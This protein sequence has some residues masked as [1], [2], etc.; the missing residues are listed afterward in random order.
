MPY[1]LMAIIFS[2]VFSVKKWGYFS[3]SNVFVFQMV[4]IK[5]AENLAYYYMHRKTISSISY[6]TIRIPCLLYTFDIFNNLIKKCFYFLCKLIIIFYFTL[7]NYLL[8]IECV[9]NY[10]LLCF[11]KKNILFFLCKLKKFAGEVQVNTNYILD[12]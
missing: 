6:E 5:K 8:R 12:R 11:S 10:M 9:D 2:Y 4:Q 7:I 3:Q 1:I